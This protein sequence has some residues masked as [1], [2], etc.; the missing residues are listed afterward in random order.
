[1]LFDTPVLIDLQR[2]SR[3]DEGGRARQFLR[4]H[5]DAEMSMSVVTAIEFAEGFAE[6]KQEYWEMMLQPFQILSVSNAVAWQG[7]QMRRRLRKDGVLNGYST[8]SAKA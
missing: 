1:M 4:A 5:S 6:D 7:G 2:E 8:F 3:R